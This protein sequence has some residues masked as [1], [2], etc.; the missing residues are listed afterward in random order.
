MSTIPASNIVQ[1][2]PGVLSAGG[3]GLILDGI[4]LTNSTRIPI[5]AVQAYPNTSTSVSA[6]FGSGAKET[7]IAS[8]YF[9]GYLN[10]TQLPQSILFAQYNQTAVPAYLRGGPINTLTIAQLQAISGT[11]SIIIDGYTYSAGSLSLSGATSYSSAAALIQTALNNTLPSG[12]S[13]TG[14]IAASTASVTGTIAGNVMY[15]TGVTSGTLQ[16]GAIISGT[17]VTAGTQIQSQLTGT[18]G[19]VGTYAVSISQVVSNAVTISATY[20]TLTV[21]AV[22]SGTL[23]IGQTLSG[24]NVT[25]G[26]QIWALGTGTGL[27]GTYIVSPSQ[28]AT[29]TAI[30]ATGSALV[31]S[32]DSVSGGLLITS[33]SIGT[34]STAAYA[35]GS[36]AAVLCLTQQTGAVLSQG[37]YAQTPSSFMNGLTAITQNWATFMTVV[38]PDGGSGN[39]QKQLFAAWTNSQNNRYCYVCW[40]GDVTPT[41][42]VPA[43]TSL[44]YILQ[45]GNSSG[46]CLIYDPANANNIAAFVCGT[47][48]SINFNIANG[49][50]TTAFKSQTGL[51]AT[52][53]N[54]TA[55]ANLAGNPL[56]AGSYGNGYNFYGAYATAAQNFVFFN[57]GT[58]SGPFLWLDSYVD[59]IWLNNALQLAL[60]NLLV[61]SNSIPYNQAG[62]AMI[63]TAVLDPVNAALNCGVIRAGVTL[64]A[65][66][67]QQV[68]LTTNVN[69]APILQQQGWYLSIQDATPQ[70][71]QGRASPPMVFYYCDGGSIQAINLPSIEVQ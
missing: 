46:T 2:I 36:T 13:V 34:S 19:G 45:Q 37:A 11:L 56:V 43:T 53:T 61:S 44:G 17:G 58:V 66:Q 57:R 7:S 68:N 62:Y 25:A 4:V 6:V 24:T 63:A 5:G 42:T 47:V 3:S 51:I 71:R 16:P 23:S 21:S 8:V 60:M 12:A 30:T 59:Q 64:S 50:I 65:N 9:S 33:G 55:A 67:I 14:A 26:T 70:V 22:S 52:V 29:S 1:I 39:A 10:C 32:Y 31:V 40:D 27:A 28:T 35:T 41:L 49:R 69:A 54:A 20:G 38:D 18:T 15:V 48:A